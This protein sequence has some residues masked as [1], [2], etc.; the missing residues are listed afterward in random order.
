MRSYQRGDSLNSIN[1]KVSAKHN[2]L[3]VRLPDKMEKRTVTILLEAA[4]IPD[5]KEDIEYVIFRS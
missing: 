4:K 1:W 5:N 2:E 3:M